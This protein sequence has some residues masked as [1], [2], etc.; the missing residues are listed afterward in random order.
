MLLIPAGVI[1]LL[2]LG[3]VAGQLFGIRVLKLITDGEVAEAT[4]VDPGRSDVAN[5]L[6]QHDF[7]VDGTTYQVDARSAVPADI[8]RC[9]VLYDRNRPRRNLGLA[10]Q[11]AAIVKGEPVAWSTL[12]LPLVPPIAAIVFVLRI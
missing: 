6:T 5:P 4:L 11:R 10:P 9:A 1:L 8:E 12:L 3:L 7:V 2:T